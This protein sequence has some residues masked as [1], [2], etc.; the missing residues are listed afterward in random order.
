M[1]GKT[2]N[3]NII[4]HTTFVISTLA[5]I[6]LILHSLAH[7]RTQTSPQQLQTRTYMQQLFSFIRVQCFEWHINN[8]TKAHKRHKLFLLLLLCWE[9]GAMV[10]PGPYFLKY[11]CQL[12]SKV[13]RWGQRPIHCDSFYDRCW[14]YQ[15]FHA[16]LC[17]I[18][19]QVFHGSA[20]GVAFLISYLL[21]YF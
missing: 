3:G 7:S 19:W 8:N 17:W 21:S 4:I 16:Y 9:M 6:S 10:N 5:C 2:S 20:L 15:V 11:S 1:E 18:S 12:H 13:V 14:L